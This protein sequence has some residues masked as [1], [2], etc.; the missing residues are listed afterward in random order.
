M[1]NFI[2]IIFFNFIKGI[3]GQTYKTL[4]IP[5]LI[6]I[7]D[8]SDSAINFYYYTTFEKNTILKYDFELEEQ[9]ISSTSEGDMISICYIYDDT[10]KH[11][12]IIVKNYLYVFSPKFINYV[13]LDYLTDRYSVLVLDECVKDEQTTSNCSLFISFINSEN[14]LEIYK[15]KFQGGTINY[16]LLKSKEIDLIKSSGEIS[17]NNC[18]Y[19]SC[20]KVKNESG[21][22]V[23]VCFYENDYSEITA[24][25]LNK[26]TLELEKKAFKKNSGAKNIKSILFN[27][28]EKVFVCYINNND[29]VAC[30]I[31]DE[32]Q[33][34][35]QNE[36]KYIEK[37]T[38]SQRYFNIDYFSSANQYMLSTYSSKTEFEYIIFDENMN[39]LDDNSIKNIEIA[40]CNDESSLL[41]ITIYYYSNYK[42]AKK[43]GNEDY[44]SNV[45]SD[46]SSSKPFSLETIFVTDNLMEL[47][48]SSLI[49]NKSLI[50]TIFSSD[51]LKGNLADKISS[52]TISKII[53]STNM[54][55]T[56]IPFEEKTSLIYTTQ[57]SS[58]NSNKIITN[59]KPP[60]I[61]SDESFSFLNDEN[62]EGEGKTVKI[63]TNKT[64][65]LFINNL[66]KVIG[67][68][69]IEKIYEIAADN[70]KIKISPLNYKDFDTD[71]SFI[72]FLDCE[73]EL[74][75]ANNLLPNENLTEVIIEIEKNDDKSLTNKIEYAVFYGKK[76]LELTVCANNEI[77]INYDISNSTLIDY[78]KI[79]DFS[80][81]GV[82]ILNIKDNFFNDIC[83][84]YAENNSDMILKD[85]I[86]DI[87][88]NFSKCDDNCEYKKIDLNLN[89]ITC[90]CKIKSKIN[91]ETE[92]P[93]LDSI[94]L[95]LLTDSSFGVIKCLSLVLN[96]HNKSENIGFWIFIL[97]IIAHIIIIIHYSIKTINP[98]NRYILTQMKKFYYI[99]HIYNPVKKRKSEKKNKFD[100]FNKF[101]IKII[102]QDQTANRRT[103]RGSTKKIFSIRKRKTHFSIRFPN[104][105]E[106]KD[107][108]SSNNN[109]ADL[110]RP[111]LRNKSKTM[112][113]RNNKDFFAK[114]K[115]LKIFSKKINSPKNNQKINYENDYNLIQINANNSSK[116]IPP[117]SQYFLDNYNY[118]EAIKYDKRPFCRIYYICILT[119]ENM[120]NIILVKSPLELQSLRICLLIF[121]YSCDLAMNTVFYFNSN[122]SD[123]YYYNGNNKFFFTMFNNLSISIISTF[124]SL[125]LE[126]FFKVMIT[127]KDDIEDLFRNEERKMRK[128]SNYVVNSIRKKQILMNIFEI[129]KKLKIKIIIFFISEFLVIVFFFYFVTAFCEVYKNSQ[130]SWITD[131]IVSFFLSFPIEF[132]NAFLIAVFYKISVQSKCKWLY[133]IAMFLYNL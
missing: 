131:S 43:C 85:R 93:R 51:N 23:L 98:I 60:N 11:I 68:I 50:D 34:V 132:G 99:A 73:N 119:K 96:F 28:N 6:S 31:F 90:N 109:L 76:Q 97:I 37:M 100:I 52:T 83:F 41:S 20:H 108:D 112:I 64:L 25:T 29:N 71:N 44:S 74:R 129:N 8:V 125:A 18:D 24:L 15:Y 117:E 55:K 114:Q 38:Q 88:Q 59:I 48:H 80:K 133:K 103:I 32:L 81:F 2:F 78:Q 120:L 115:K 91:K 77:E 7:L 39:I 16:S 56:S 107:K 86:S 130:I 53:S 95:D 27:N 123:K 3:V 63:R 79:N 118:T 111:R 47:P 84:P 121:T 58:I 36:F 5:K 22:E 105:H 128:N 113:I 65:D 45:I 49:T 19:I 104:K 122:I 87:Y 67:E 66:E 126:V 40:P 14:K 61:S 12:Y 35:F 26:D 54:L 110:S 13:K 101:H 21:L 46:V 75:K 9:K 124:I 70:F 82:D 10:H 72:N 89:L 4:I 57:L 17:L 1:K 116:N 33:N 94:L 30:L 106:D 42:I 69:N 127:S 102:N 62:V 92:P